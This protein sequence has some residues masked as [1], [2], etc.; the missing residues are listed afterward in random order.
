MRYLAAPKQVGSQ[1]KPFWLFT[2]IHF[3]QARFDHFKVN[4]NVAN[5]DN[6][7]DSIIWA[8][9]IAFNVNG[10]IHNHTGKKFFSFLTVWLTRLTFPLFVLKFSKQKEVIE[11]KNET[12][13]SKI[14]EALF[15][16]RDIKKPLI[17]EIRRVQIEALFI[18]NFVSLRKIDYLLY[19]CLFL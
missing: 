5:I 13:R 14:I 12:N 15:L 16:V 19:F 10:H 4:V 1:V 3:G 7:K 8:K 17:P 11:M 6:D 2:S 9:A 18:L